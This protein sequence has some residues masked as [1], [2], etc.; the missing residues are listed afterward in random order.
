MILS[1]TPGRMMIIYADGDFIGV[2]TDSPLS[3]GKDEQ[4]VFCE[5]RSIFPHPVFSIFE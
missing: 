5:I 3:S 2:E 1:K 4:Q